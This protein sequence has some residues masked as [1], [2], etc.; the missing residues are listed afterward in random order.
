MAVT[1]IIRIKM[2][3]GPLEFG[4]MNV[5]LVIFNYIFTYLHRRQLYFMM[6]LY[7]NIKLYAM[8]LF[9]TKKKFNCNL[10]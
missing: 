6:K 5:T 8:F 3:Y 9:N 7:D 1:N 10:K 2:D 4:S